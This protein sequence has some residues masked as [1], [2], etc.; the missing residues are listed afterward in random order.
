M[1]TQKSLGPNTNV[2]ICFSA[3]VGSQGGRLIN[4]QQSVLANEVP[5]CELLISDCWGICVFWSSIF[6]A[7]KGKICK[8]LE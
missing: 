8:P 6:I 3:G 2:G 4:T 5:K 7:Y 1:R